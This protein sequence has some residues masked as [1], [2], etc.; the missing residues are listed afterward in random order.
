MYEL[1]TKVRTKVCNKCK[2][3]KTASV[4]YWNKDSSHRD[5]L[6]NTCK[7]CSRKS[8]I[9]YYYKNKDKIKEYRKEYMKEYRKKNKDKLGEYSKEY[10]KKNK[11][12]YKEYYEKNKEYYK[13]YYKK[14]KDRISEGV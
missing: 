10:Y 3:S 9:E 13:E 8:S 12:Y 1:I 6:H 4:D 14:N 5:G 7:V 2:Q 11:E